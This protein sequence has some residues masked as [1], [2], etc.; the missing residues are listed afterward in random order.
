ML[1]LVKFV[2]CVVL[3]FVAALAMYRG[4]ERPILRLKERF[5]S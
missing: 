2:A 1:P 5:K 3:T 4:F